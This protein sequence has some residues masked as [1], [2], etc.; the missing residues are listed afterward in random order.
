MSSKDNPIV[1]SHRDAATRVSKYLSEAHGVTLKPIAALEVV[2]RA[3]G[4][5]NWQ[6]LK[7]MAEQGR[8]PRPGDGA[9]FIGKPEHLPP[10][11]PGSVLTGRLAAAK[12]GGTS[13]EGALGAAEQMS[14]RPIFR[15]GP[16]KILVITDGESSRNKPDLRDDQSDVQSM[17]PPT[18]RDKLWSA[19][20][21]RATEHKSS[22]LPDVEPLL[23]WVQ[24]DQL[25]VVLTPTQRAAVR[26]ALHSPLSIVSGYPDSGKALIAEAIVQVAH[27]AGLKNIVNARRGD[28]MKVDGAN[29]E[30]P[31][32]RHKEVGG[33]FSSLSVEHL[34]PYLAGSELLIIDEHVIGDKYVFWDVVRAAP[35]NCRI[36]ILGQIPME[37][38]SEMSQMLS[39]LVKRNFATFTQLH[40]IL[41]QQSLR[42]V[43]IADIGGE[44]RGA[45]HQSDYAIGETKV[46]SNPRNY[47]SGDSTLPGTD[48]TVAGTAL[49]GTSARYDA[50]FLPDV[51]PSQAW[52]VRGYLYAPN[53]RNFVSTKLTGKWCIK[54]DKDK[55]DDLWAKVCGEIRTYRLF[56][57]LVSSPHNAQAHG[58]TYIICVFTPDWADEDDV[59]RA[60]QVLRELGVTEEI[61]YKR[62]IETANGVYGTP[63][64]WFY[65]A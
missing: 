40:E 53:A 51:K 26:N 29:V 6:T 35:A 13:Y 10:V 57:A 54:C 3:L 12:Q 2:A 14:L 9:W 44:L 59:M 61:G 48:G 22:P 56:T 23:D 60:R 65:R 21:R 17:S 62:D 50:K 58:G 18:A 28:V 15:Q 46:V 43:N 39:D 30:I 64:E 20:V 33:A 32:F 41:R 1:S 31:E 5:N 47:P 24:H 38:S 49:P 45:S 36:V 7:A 16:E 42:F 37:D 34:G 52:D 19:L 63:A 25:K 55:V 11:G 8:V 4:A 27:L